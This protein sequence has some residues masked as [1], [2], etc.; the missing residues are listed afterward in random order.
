MR[1]G[2]KHNPSIQQKSCV[3]YSNT[4]LLGMSI[5][6]C[7]TQVGGY[8]WYWLVSIR[9][10]AVSHP[11]EP[12]TG[13]WVC[14]VCF[15]SLRMQRRLSKWKKSLRRLLFVQSSDS[16][17]FS[18]LGMNFPFHGEVGYPMLTLLSHPFLEAMMSSYL[19]SLD[20]FLMTVAAASGHFC[21]WRITCGEK[22]LSTAIGHQH[23]DT[24][25]LSSSIRS[26]LPS[27]FCLAALSLSNVLKFSMLLNCYW[28]S[29]SWF[30]PTAVS[31]KPR[32]V[33]TFSSFSWTSW[34]PG[35]FCLL[36]EIWTVH[37]K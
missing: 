34:P 9:G 3:S 32:K 5:K 18:D 37:L 4:G 20:L 15:A 12:N 28:G 23:T 13:R 19:P 26:A 35:T 22:G 29:L 2:K 16:F 8:I 24:I 27:W 36:V 33:W 25:P 10:L 17:D 30:W 21:S 7:R 11:V 6:V 1:K 14:V 31:A